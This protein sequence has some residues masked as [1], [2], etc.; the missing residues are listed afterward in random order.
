MYDV[1]FNGMVYKY[2][3]FLWI[4]EWVKISNAT[5]VPIDIRFTELEIKCSESCML[6]ESVICNEAFSWQSSVACQ[7]I[8]Y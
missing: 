1:N 4:A 3:I 6:S 8:L 2:V 7:V 5:L